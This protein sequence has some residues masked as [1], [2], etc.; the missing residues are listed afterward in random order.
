MERMEGEGHGVCFLGG[1]SLSRTSKGVVY[2]FPV[3]GVKKIQTH[4][5]SVFLE[6]KSS[7]LSQKILCYSQDFAIL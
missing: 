1:V 7:I 4:N 5:Y 3:L 2:P 6:E